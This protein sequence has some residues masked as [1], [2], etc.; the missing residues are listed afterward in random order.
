M[1]GG[2]RGGGGGGGDTS[3]IPRPTLPRGGCGNETR[4][5]NH[6][7]LSS[8]HQDIMHTL[9]ITY[10]CTICFLDSNLFESEKT[11]CQYSSESKTNPHWMDGD[12]SSTWGIKVAGNH[13]DLSEGSVGYGT[14]IRQP[15][16]SVLIKFEDV[17]L[18]NH[19]SLQLLA[20]VS[21]SIQIS[22][23]NKQWRKL[24]D[25][26]NFTCSGEQQLYFPKQAIQ[27]ANMYIECM[28]IEKVQVQCIL[29]LQVMYT[30]R[31]CWGDVSYLKYP[32]G[33]IWQIYQTN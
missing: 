24:F 5:Y 2:G 3:L 13:F 15:P 12:S 31:L 29:S 21:Y 25:Y 16:T 1:W 19:I 9:A 20:P 14:R 28:T 23:D 11:S 17:Y 18:V 32:L 33:T 8:L 26:T 4:V 30:Q 10:S 22:N 27:Y 7:H 6:M